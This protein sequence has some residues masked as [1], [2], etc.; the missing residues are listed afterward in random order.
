MKNQISSVVALSV[1][2]VSL[3][4]SQSALSQDAKI[5]EAAVKYRQGAFSMIG[6]HIGPLGAMAKGEM[7]FDAA[8][9]A[10]NAQAIADLAKYPENAFIDGS[11]SDDVET[12]AKPEIWSDAA[13]FGEKLEAFKSASAELASTAAGAASLDDV[14]GA[15]GALGKSCKGCHDDYRHKKE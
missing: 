9:F 5:I 8:T 13:G 15:F 6:W 2:S 7:E 11:S 1:L 3:L 12:R 14:K 4:A 10:S